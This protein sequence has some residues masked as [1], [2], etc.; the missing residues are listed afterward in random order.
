M[1]RTAGDIDHTGTPGRDDYREDGEQ[2][3]ESRDFSGFTDPPGGPTDQSPRR[4]WRDP[5]TVQAMFEDMQ[6]QIFDLQQ[7]VQDQGKTQQD[8]AYCITGDTIGPSGVISIEVYLKR[9]KD[10]TVGPHWTDQHRILLARKNMSGSALTR[11]NNRGMC[12]AVNWINFKREMKE[13]FS[14]MPE[15]RQAA[16]YNYQPIRKNGESVSAL[17][18]RIANDLDNFTET[19]TMPEGQKLEE[20]KSVLVRVLPPQLHY[21]IGPSVDMLHKLM[22]KL[23][24]RV[25][26]RRELKLALTDIT[27]EKLDETWKIPMQ[28]ST[29]NAISAA[30]TAPPAAAVTAASTNPVLV[31]VN[32]PPPPLSQQTVAATAS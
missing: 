32:P 25:C 21:G 16:W 12:D 23:E 26:K 17:I 22:Q 4:M 3:E 20:V 7:Q 14:I 1:S 9:I 2:S 11:F 24:I 8:Q 27:S 28:N 31:N 5:D 29:V 19:G 18:D 6:H 30:T 10:N 13:T 15:L